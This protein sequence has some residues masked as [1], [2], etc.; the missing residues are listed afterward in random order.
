[1]Q[2]APGQGMT[3]DHKK[4]EAFA[5]ADELALAVHRT[6]SR[7]PISERFGMQAQL[8]GAAL[9]VP[10]QIVAGCGRR[11]NHDYLE[12]LTLALDA[13]LELRYLFSLAARLELLSAQ[14][15]KLLDQQAQALVRSLRRLIETWS[16]KPAKTPRPRTPSMKLKSPSMKLKSPSLKP[17]A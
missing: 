14:E 13:A 3:R 8:R 17:K 7:L 6:T 10:V 12:F 4:L 2:G 11:S 15:M 16:D 1:M 5:I 9:R